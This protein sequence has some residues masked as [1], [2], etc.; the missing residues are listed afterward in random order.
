MSSSSSSFSSISFATSEEEVEVEAYS[1]SAYV[2]PERR[3]IMITSPAT[4]AS[5]PI[6]VSFNRPGGGEPATPDFHLPSLVRLPTLTPSPNLI[7][8]E[9]SGLFQ[10]YIREEEEATLDASGDHHSTNNIN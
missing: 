9:S 4:F 3:P 6:A 5:T 8:P 7:R 1:S 10:R 2:T